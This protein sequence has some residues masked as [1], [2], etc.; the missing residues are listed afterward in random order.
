VPER[1]NLQDNFLNEVRKSRVEVIVYL[2]HGF[3]LRGT[4]RAFDPFTIL[5]DH[6]GKEQ[7]VYKHA[8]ST[9]VKSPAEPGREE[10]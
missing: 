5:L 4:I 3:Q 2:L 8:V 6:N 7:L 10:I 1:P 9:V